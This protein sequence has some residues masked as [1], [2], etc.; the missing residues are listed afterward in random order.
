MRTALRRAMRLLVIL[1]VAGTMNATLTAQKVNRSWTGLGVKGYDV[2]AYFTQGAP[3]EGSSAFTHVHGGVTYRFISA[4]NRDA[5]VAAPNRY[6]PQYGGYC[7]YA[8][9][10]NYTAD[11]DPT[12]WRIVDG[13]LF[14]NYNARAQEKWAADVAASISQ[15]DANW[16]A[17]SRK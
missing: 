7:A 8:V 3:V 10:R 13:R 9:S 6:L 16:P 15:G 2:V 12:A 11:I 1:L 17:L 4:A 5:F 14:L